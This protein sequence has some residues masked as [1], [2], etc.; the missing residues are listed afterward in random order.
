M[1]HANLL[2]LLWFTSFESLG[3]L[4]V[5][6]YIMSEGDFWDERNK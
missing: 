5:N 6:K 3:S 4:V 2:A 1:C